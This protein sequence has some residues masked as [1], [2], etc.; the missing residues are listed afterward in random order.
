M[1]LLI[2]RI[3]KIADLSAR[4]SGTNFLRLRHQAA[5]RVLL[6]NMQKRGELTNERRLAIA[7]TT[8]NPVL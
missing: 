7:W 5:E 8:Q 6:D 4:K 3:V 1:H 2:D